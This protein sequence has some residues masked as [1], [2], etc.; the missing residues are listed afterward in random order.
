MNVNWCGNS[1]LVI[2]TW[3]ENV[4][5][6]RRFKQ[7]KKT[8]SSFHDRKLLCKVCSHCIDAGYFNTFLSLQ[9]LVSLI[10]V[11]I[12]TYMLYF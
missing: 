4:A 7:S 6:V 1:R 9:H 3:H 5:E 2:R 10:G 8:A 11:V 12:T